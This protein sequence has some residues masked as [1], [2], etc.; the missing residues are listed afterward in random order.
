MKSIATA[1]LAAALLLS[2]SSAAMAAQN[3]SELTND[4]MAALRNSMK[5]EP[6]ETKEAFRKEWQIRVTRMTPEERATLT[7][8]AGENS[9]LSVDDDD[10]DCQ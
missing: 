10:S 1:A 6:E 7:K 2:C 4:E 8:S 9:A 3:F 5:H